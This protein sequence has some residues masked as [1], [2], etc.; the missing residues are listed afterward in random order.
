MVLYNEDMMYTNSVTSVITLLHQFTCTRH[1]TNS[2]LS[3]YVRHQNISICLLALVQVRPTIMPI[4]FV[5]L[6]T[7]DQEYLC[8]FSVHLLAVFC[9]KTWC[10]TYT[11]LY[12]RHHVR[13]TPFIT[14]C[15]TPIFSFSLRGTTYLDHHKQLAI[16]Y[17][18]I[19]LNLYDLKKNQKVWKFGV[20][21]KIV[22]T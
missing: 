21:R 18:E 20:G 17:E 4:C 1:C 7:T 5:T 8:T 13:P 10:R 12:V 3:M 9:V 15:Q 16:N 22:S 6:M 2:K 14:W 19:I 11:F